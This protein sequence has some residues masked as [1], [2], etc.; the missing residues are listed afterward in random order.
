MIVSDAELIQ[1]NTTEQTPKLSW[2]TNRFAAIYPTLGCYVNQD[3]LED[4]NFIDIEYCSMSKSESTALAQDE[5]NKF[6][7]TLKRNGIEIE[8]FEQETDTPDSVCTDW[9]MTIRN[10]IFPKGVLVL[11]AMK[12][13]QRR[14]ER[15]QKIIDILANYYEDII[16]LVEFEQQNKALELR[17]SL[18]CDWMNAKIYWSLS[19]RSDKDV[20]EYLIEE[21]NKISMKH[22]SKNITGITFCSYDADDNQ[23]YHT[24]VMLAILDKHVVMWADMIKDEQ[25]REALVEE[26]TSAEHNTHA[27]ELV[28][29]S[30]EECLNMWANIIFAKDRNNNSCIIMSDRANVNFKR[31]NKRILS[32][33]YK[34][35]KTDL[36]ILERISGASAKSLLSEIN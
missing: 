31:E 4:N 9:F 32:K 16:D 20:F 25:K 18:V 24:D 29:I 30:E 14:K 36:S 34:I 15:S 26:L 27:R 6:T 19:Q 21:L 2:Y 28:K 5:F 10:E 7:R 3:T 22:T 35:I 12:T 1:G 33:N 11:G 17:G 8:T 13:E 23:I